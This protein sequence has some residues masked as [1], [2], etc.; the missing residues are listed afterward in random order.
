[1]LMFLVAIST[2][3]HSLA[4]AVMVGHYFLLAL[5]YLPVYESQLNEAAVSKLLENISGRLRPFIGGSVLILL[6]TGTYLMMTNQN[7]LGIGNFSNLWGIMI[8]VKHMVVLAMI[9]LGVYAERVLSP[10]L[11]GR[12]LEA[13]YQ[14]RLAMSIMLILGVLVLLLTTIAQSV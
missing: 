2:W 7:Y 3:L 10:R 5:V 8:V 4:T 1:M 11:S 13:L 12:K 14:F 6:I 9:V